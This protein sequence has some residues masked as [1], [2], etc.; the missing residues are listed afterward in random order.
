[1]NRTYVTDITHFLDEN[2]HI[3]DDLP[4][5]AMQLLDNLGKVIVL[6]TSPSDSDS[7]T[8]A[9]LPCWGID[10][11]QQCNGTVKVGFDPKNHNILWAC[12]KCGDNGT[13]SNWENSFWN[14]IDKTKD[15]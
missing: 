14:C 9:K 13:I 7:K 2:G 4:E 5:A 6:A 3:P 12:C 1:M 8:I 11:N 15:N 10:N